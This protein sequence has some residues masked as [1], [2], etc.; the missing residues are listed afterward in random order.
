M[1]KLLNFKV[2][3]KIVL[4]NSFSH[5]TRKICY[6]SKGDR[7]KMKKQVLNKK[8]LFIAIVLIAL[9]IASIIFFSKPRYEGT[10]YNEKS[11]DTKVI[12]IINA[13]QGKTLLQNKNF[14]N[15]YVN[16]VFQEES[17]LMT[18]YLIDYKTGEEINI[19]KIIKEECIEDFKNKI[20]E[21]LYLKYPKFIADAV[22]SNEIK[23]AYE[24]KENELIIH[25]DEVKTNP[26]YELPITLKVNY[27]EIKEFI[28]FNVEL[29]GEYENE[30]GYLFDKNKKTVAL[31]FDDGPSGDKTNRLVNLLNENKMHA[32]FFMV[33]YRMAN[34]PDLIKNLREKGNEVGS[35]SYRHEKLTKLTKEEL[36]TGEKNTFNIYKS[37]TG[38]DLKLLRPPYGSVNNIMK[39]SLDYV[40]VNWNLDTEDWRYRNA[41]HI[42]DSVIKNIDDGDIILMHDL[43]DT[44]VEAVERLLPELYIRG[45]QVVTVSELA[46]LKGVT[47]EKGKVIRGL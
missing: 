44:T 10:Y 47:L 21:L 35:H 14:E 17:N 36:V 32:T 29:S 11:I 4:K 26:V 18:S 20:K 12:E 31:T 1:Y 40:F 42:Y 38:E 37:I 34:A 46:N 8:R 27:H 25:Y 3:A 9:L 19:E 45:Y 5:E 41:N 24:F 43:Y 6:T 23:I 2:E 39:E 16:L 22:I 7:M 30:N 33:G 13:N 28:N 15:K